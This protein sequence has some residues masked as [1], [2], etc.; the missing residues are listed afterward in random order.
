MNRKTLVIIGLQ[1]IIIVVLFWVLVFYGKD[2]YEAATGDHDATITSPS[3]VTTENGAP[4]IML[5]VES[6]QQSAITTTTLQAAEH[7]GVISSF[8]VVVGIDP[9][10]EQRTRYLSAIAEANVIKAALANS[11]RESERMAQLNQDNRNV[12]DRAAA[13][14]KATM[15]ADEAR[16][17]AAETAAASLQDSMRL[18]WGETL[19]NW[20]VQQPA[21]DVL[22]KLLQHTE[23][24]VQVALPMDAA[25]PG[26]GA[27]LQL[28]A[29]GGTGGQIQ[30]G[31]ISASP[32]TD[33]TLQG[34]TFYYHAPAQYLRTGMRVS[35]HLATQNQKLS[36]VI[37]PATAVVWYANQPWV[38][39]KQGK[40][41]FVRHPIKTDTETDNGWFNATS[42]N[43]GD[44][45]VTTGAQLLL[46]EEFK[47][48]IKNENE[49]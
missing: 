24:L 42:L 21:G 9:L 39:Q 35:A 48:Q 11:R 38:Y 47:Y 4:T 8:G 37:I 40:D 31:Y 30:A 15:Q 7:L 32:Q 45:V 13:A 29:I 44:E 43:A 16:L 10:V 12:S 22:Q 18:Q 33:A 28:E 23:V 17:A 20:A 41:K 6:Q 25:Q 49:D 2:E 46:S 34:A 1:A 19:A 14:A 36:G 26:K 5:S 27:L 3:H